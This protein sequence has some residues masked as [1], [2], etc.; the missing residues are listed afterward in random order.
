MEPHP[1]RPPLCSPLVGPCAC[2]LAVASV[3]L[4]SCVG[5]DERRHS[6]GDSGLGATEPAFGVEVQRYPAGWIVGPRAELPIGAD[7]VL[8][9][10]LSWNAADRGDFGRHDDEQGGGLG[11]GA[12]WRR[13][14]SQDRSGW[15]WGL[16]ADF[17]WLDIDWE[18]DPPTA[19]QGDTGVLVFQPAV[20]A[21]YR[22]RFGQSRWCLDLT[23]SVGLE[24]N[25][26]TDGENVGQGPIG[27]LGATLCWGL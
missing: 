4:S 25:L 17:W 12:G 21:G 1:P 27:L 3:A 15:L 19:D 24:I 2:A 8:V 23:A 14:Q 7:E 22:L 26:V 10:R 18:D 13:Y 20:E 16:R 5:L 9:A 6:A 11:G